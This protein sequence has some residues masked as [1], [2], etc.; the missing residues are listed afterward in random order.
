MSDLQLCGGDAY[1]WVA[2]EKWYW[3]KHQAAEINGDLKLHFEGLA[4][5]PEGESA[6]DNRLGIAVGFRSDPAPRNRRSA[7]SSVEHSKF[8][9]EPTM[10]A[11]GK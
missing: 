5:D 11:L 6:L 8:A 10:D 3:K 7:S 9:P 2:G 1:L 4:K